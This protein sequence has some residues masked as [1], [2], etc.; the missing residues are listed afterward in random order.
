MECNHKNIDDVYWGFCATC[1]C[2]FFWKECVT[3]LKS[4]SLTAAPATFCN[5][6]KYHTTLHRRRLCLLVT[7]C[8]PC[9]TDFWK[10]LKYCIQNRTFQFHNL[11]ANKQNNKQKDKHIHHNNGAHLLYDC[12][13]HAATLMACFSMMAG[14]WNSQCIQSHAVNQM[15]DTPVQHTVMTTNQ[16]TGGCVHLWGDLELTCYTNYSSLFV[17][18]LGH[19]SRQEGHPAVAAEEVF[20]LPWTLVDIPWLPADVSHLL[21]CGWWQPAAQWVV[22]TSNEQ[23]LNMSTAHIHSTKDKC[24][25]WSW[26]IHSLI[27]NITG[28]STGASTFWFWASNSWTLACSSLNW[29][30]SCGLWEAVAWTPNTD[31]PDSICD[32]KESGNISKASI[33]MTGNHRLLSHLWHYLPVTD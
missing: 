16:S 20:K 9:T 22:V 8:L 1:D 13:V 2:L 15:S 23:R 5:T 14:T 3:K 32:S 7:E 28:C 6:L 27:L 19:A 33:H 18:H 29:A 26:H 30:T 21:G 17:C 11:V 4:C 31:E 25:S 12:S 10:Q 24:E